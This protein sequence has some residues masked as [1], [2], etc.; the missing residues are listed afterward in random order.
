MSGISHISKLKHR[1]LR[2][3]RRLP[4]HNLKQTSSSKISTTGNLHN[5]TYL[6]PPKTT[7]TSH[8]YNSQLLSTWPLRNLEHLMPPRT[9][10]T[11]H[12]S[13]LYLD[14]F[15]VH[16]STLLRN[17]REEVGAVV[18]DR[19]PWRGK[20]KKHKSCNRWKLIKILVIFH[21]VNTVIYPLHSALLIS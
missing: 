16:L 12:F 11:L 17:R 10:P 4:L 6:I 15:L 1:L 21:E 18:M 19:Q 5:D 3:L 7:G 20:P 8:S 9:V 13:L 2:N 14:V